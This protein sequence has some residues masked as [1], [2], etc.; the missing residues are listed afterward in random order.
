MTMEND[1]DREGGCFC[2][3]VRFRASGPPEWVAHCHCR[4]CRRATGSPL[5]TYAGYGRENVN[6]TSGQAKQRQSSPGTW[7]GWCGDCGTPLF[8]RSERWPE[9][10][11]LF[12]ATFEA[13]DSFQPQGHV[14]VREQLVWIHL[15][16][17]LPRFETT[18]VSSA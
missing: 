2:G 6:F 10:I 14:Y 4:D 5:T 18:G 12:V 8:Y 3:A 16:D 11:H 13:P 1:A 7:R 15:S 9:E 17:S